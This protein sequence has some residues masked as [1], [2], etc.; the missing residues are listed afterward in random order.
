MLLVH[1]FFHT[2]LYRNVSGG[3]GGLSSIR[4]GDLLAVHAIPISVRCAS[5]AKGGGVEGSGVCFGVWA[6]CFLPSVVALCELSIVSDFVERVRLHN[7]PVL[8]DGVQLVLKV[9]R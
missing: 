9:H 5:E 6:G 1:R 4:I 7:L 3:Q 2:L 8:K